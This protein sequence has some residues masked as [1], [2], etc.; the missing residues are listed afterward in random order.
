M[1]LL[2]VQPFL[3]KN[4][5]RSLLAGELCAISFYLTTLLPLIS[6]I[7]LSVRKQGSIC[8][9]IV[10]VNIGISV[11]FSV[12]STTK[13]I[14]HWLKSRKL[15]DANNVVPTSLETMNEKD[16]LPHKLNTQKG[17][18]RKTLDEIQLKNMEGYFKQ[19]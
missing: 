6:V 11:F 12:I 10:L 3:D 4:M 17:E 19:R 7:S 8:I 2:A 13:A 5:Q 16:R 18:Y 15:R 1:Y 9:I 14:F